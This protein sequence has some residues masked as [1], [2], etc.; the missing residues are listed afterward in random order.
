MHDMLYKYQE[1]WSQISDVRVFFENYAQAIGLDVEQFKADRDSVRV[2]NIV[3]EDGTDGEVRGVRN[4][5]TIFINDVESK[6]AFTKE[7]LKEAID[8]ALASKKP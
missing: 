1:V 7:K 4:T 3:I 2:E 8:A 5:P 6:T